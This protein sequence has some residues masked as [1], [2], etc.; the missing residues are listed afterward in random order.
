MCL[1]FQF[2]L[3]KL[4]HEGGYYIQ[5]QQLQ[6]ADARSHLEH[7]C[8]LDID[9]EP[10]MVRMSGIICTIGKKYILCG[11]LVFVVILK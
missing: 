10:H 2:D 4:E 9:S 3:T 5:A 8:A 6:A 11:D 7:M 1:C